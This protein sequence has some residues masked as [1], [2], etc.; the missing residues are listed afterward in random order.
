VWFQS[1]VGSAVGF[2]FGCVGVLVVEQVAVETGAGPAAAV[3]VVVV[4]AAAAAAVVEDPKRVK[5]ERFK[6]DSDGTYLDR[7]W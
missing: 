6:D 7:W 4:A 2:G 1:A 3:D 5:S